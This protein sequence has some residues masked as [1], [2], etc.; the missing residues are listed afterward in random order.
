VTV[1]EVTEL[2]RAGRIEPKADPSRRLAPS[3][4]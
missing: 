3:A 2:L 1:L 4:A